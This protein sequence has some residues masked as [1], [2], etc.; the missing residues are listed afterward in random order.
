[1][2]LQ[3]SLERLR[4]VD[5]DVGNVGAWPRAIRL[6]LLAA[7]G[8]A[9]LA[10]GSILHVGQRINDLTQAQRGEAGLLADYRRLHVATVDVALAEGE[11]HRAAQR[12][13]SLL[14]RLPGDAEVPA[15]IDDISRAALSQQLAIERITL[16]EE[17]AMTN[18]VELP[19]DIAVTG[20]YHDI[21]AFL[22]ALAELPRILAP[23]D[24]GLRT[25]GSAERLELTIRA[26]TWRRREVQGGAT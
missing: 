24:F 12:F 23:Q 21:G 13:E 11:R 4:E 16:G 25:Q 14:A 20:G 8:V 1:M 26:L 10:G 17:R 7:A 5:L 19:I 15:L 9:L 18:H 3:E 2:Q 6:A 22:E